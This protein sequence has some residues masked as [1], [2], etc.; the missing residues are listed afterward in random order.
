MNDAVSSIKTW[1]LG[2][3]ARQ[4][5][6]N[7]SAAKVALEKE[8]QRAEGTK[9]Q[10]VQN[11]R[12]RR[13]RLW[14]LQIQAECHLMA[15]LLQIIGA[16]ESWT[17]MVK[18]GYKLKRAWGFYQHCRKKLRQLIQEWIAMGG[19]FNLTE[20]YSTPTGNISSGSESDNEDQTEMKTLDSSAIDTISLEKKLEELHLTDAKEECSFDIFG[21]HDLHVDGADLAALRL[22]QKLVLD[23]D[24][25]IRED[26]ELSSLRIGLEFGAGA[27]NLFVS[28][29]PSSY[30]KAIEIMG[31]PGE[32]EQGLSLL[33]KVAATNHPRSPLASLMLLQY[34][35]TIMGLLS[36]TEE[37]SK[38]ARAV[39]GNLLPTWKGGSIFRLLQSRLLCYE[40]CI[41]EA[42]AIVASLPTKVDSYS[43][44]TR[45]CNQRLNFL[46]M[47]ELGWCLLLQGKFATAADCFY[48]LFL[49]TVSFKLYY[50]CLQAVCLWQ[51]DDESF[52][53]RAA[54]D[55]LQSLPDLRW[56][57]QE[58]GPLEQYGLSIADRFINTNEA[59]Q[60]PALEMASFY[61]GFQHMDKATIE[62]H[63]QCIEQALHS[64]Q[65]K[66]GRRPE[67][68]PNGLKRNEMVCR[69]LLGICQKCMGTKEK[70][71]ENFRYV[72]SNSEDYC[73]NIVPYSC[74]ELAC[75]LLEVE[76]TAQEGMHLLEQSLS[77]SAHEF[78][79]RLK[80]VVC[81]VLKR[82]GYQSSSFS[83]SVTGT[84]LNLKSVSEQFIKG[85]VNLMRSETSK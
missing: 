72:I 57:K 69:Y 28:L 68:Q 51:A 20:S 2:K 60:L 49:E 48:R 9:D 21:P 3:I 13:A 70:A 32:R 52:Q 58:H 59:P 53:N 46:I 23:T 26:L 78:Q 64:N 30:Q 25:D 74:Y 62:H 65:P 85:A 18:V 56:D 8:E 79:G 42:S 82:Y 7:I 55:L 29:I 24:K 35:T 45:L 37:H 34:H 31:V 12:A 83:S 50:A 84:G 36:S 75:M 14:A 15:S 1:A 67:Y 39:F 10:L 33:G 41:K 27:I 76:S 71:E 19:S 4:S 54:T 47:D 66:Y 6:I 38:A 73:G 22:D 81:E 63:M 43:K 80:F 44:N 11:H 17:A 5:V 40:G 16:G 61:N 77:Y